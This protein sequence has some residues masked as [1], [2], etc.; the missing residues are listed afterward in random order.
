MTDTLWLICLSPFILLGAI[1]NKYAM[2]RQ[3]YGNNDIFHYFRD[4]LPSD[5][6]CNDL[7]N[8]RKWLHKYKQRQ[9]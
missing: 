1:V 7:P 5:Y 9:K 8:K 2:T 3:V 6:E 4:E